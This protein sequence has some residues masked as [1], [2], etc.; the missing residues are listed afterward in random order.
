M[1]R[2]REFVD[3]L[4]AWSPVLLLGA[5]A[6]LTYW[7]DAQVQA[8]A[9]RRDGSSRHEPDLFLQDFKAVTF[10]AGG[11]PREALSA[12]LAQHFPD[13]NS[14]ELSNPT[15]SLTEPGRPTLTIRADRG[16]I[17][18][19]REHGEFAGHVHVEREADPQPAQGQGPSGP[20]TLD[21]DTLQ[22]LVKEQRV[23]TDSPVTI[24]EPRGIIRGRGLDFDN[25]AKR[26]RV[27][28]QVSGTLQPQ[29]TPR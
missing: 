16:S 7:L 19:D 6:A 9:A 8:P 10:D 28:S 23:H 12:G 4:V 5:L 2:T 22:V 18:G 29:E 25:K 11:K 1:D 15:L 26:V 21:T 13:D 17:T 27:R 14:A 3:R 20:V 24:E